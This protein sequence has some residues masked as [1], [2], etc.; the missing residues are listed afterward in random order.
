MSCILQKPKTFVS[1]PSGEDNRV[2]HNLIKLI[3][4]VAQTE[5]YKETK[6]PTGLSTSG[7]QIEHECNLSLVVE[8]CRRLSACVVELCVKRI[9]ELGVQ[10]RAVRMTERRR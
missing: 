6:R 2:S 3:V 5:F 7:S 4:N 8:G 1:E 9:L 10:R